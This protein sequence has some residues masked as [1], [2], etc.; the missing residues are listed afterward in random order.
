MQGLYDRYTVIDNRT[1]QQVEDGFF[2]LKLDRPRG[3]E[4]TNDLRRVY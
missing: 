2:V 4:G 1:G 3:F